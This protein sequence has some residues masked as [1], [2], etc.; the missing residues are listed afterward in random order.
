M[1]K[2]INLFKVPGDNLGAAISAD[3]GK[4]KSFFCPLW[5]AQW[6]G[7]NEPAHGVI[8]NQRDNSVVYISFSV[9]SQKLNVSL[10]DNGRDASTNWRVGDTFTL[11]GNPYLNNGPDAIVEVT[12]IT[13]NQTP[14]S[15][16]IIA[17]LDGASTAKT[18]TKM[19]FHNDRRLRVV[20]ADGTDVCKL[21]AA[22]P[23]AGEMNIIATDS[24]GNT[25]YVTRLAEHL[26]VVTRN[27]GSSHQFDT[28]S[29]VKWNE[30][31]AV[32]NQS[33]KI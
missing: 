33:V 1:S 6:V 19:K 31:G 22:A 13:P 2:I 17:R 20:N 5:N 25:Y 30:T 7:V 23:A 3:Q 28:G 12:E 32:A 4:P 24:A 26:A 16:T 29:R 14:G 18:V 10:L 9:D 11:Q 21:V 8:N 27:T 15:A